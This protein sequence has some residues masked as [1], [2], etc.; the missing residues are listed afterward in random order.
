MPTKYGIILLKS[1]ECTLKIYENSL[2]IDNLVYIKQFDSE[3]ECI[4]Y[5]RNKNLRIQKVSR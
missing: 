4:E 3:K 2:R 5:A 1:N